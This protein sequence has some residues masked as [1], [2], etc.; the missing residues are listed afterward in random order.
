MNN[1]SGKF[2]ANSKDNG[3]NGNAAPTE[4]EKSPILRMPF[5][6][7]ILGSDQKSGD[8]VFEGQVSIKYGPEKGDWLKMPYM[9]MKKLIDFCMEN[10]D[11]FNEYMAK[12]R[13]KMVT[14]DL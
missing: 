5:G 11:H 8:R 4:Y 9:D 1:Q 3:N 6:L 13:S 12:E 14:G 10:R 2:S 7:F